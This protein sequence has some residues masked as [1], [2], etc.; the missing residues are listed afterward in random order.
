MTGLPKNL[1]TEDSLSFFVSTASTA[2]TTTIG[3]KSSLR[4][5]KRM[6]LV[7]M[8]R[9]DE[10]VTR[11][12]EDRKAFLS[13][14]CWLYI[15]QPLALYV[16]C[17]HINIEKS[18]LLSEKVRVVRRMHRFRTALASLNADQACVSLFPSSTFDTPMLLVC[19]E[20]TRPSILV[21]IDCSSAYPRVIFLC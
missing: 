17:S 5:R 3:T 9:V 16:R 4:A 6:S 10:R 15:R 12:F 18:C 1:N 7:S 2:G 8:S 13:Q 11:G 21:C 14:V 20:G 19:P